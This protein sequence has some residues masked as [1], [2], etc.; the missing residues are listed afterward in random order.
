MKSQI[1]IASFVAAST[2][3]T[4]NLNTR[5]TRA[6]GAVTDDEIIETLLRQDAFL[7]PKNSTYID[8]ADCF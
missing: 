3:L 5:A 4:T 2:A 1:L 7:L 8:I 6:T